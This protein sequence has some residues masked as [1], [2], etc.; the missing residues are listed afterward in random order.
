MDI[1]ERS[2]QECREPQETHCD[3]DRALLRD[4]EEHQSGRMISQRWHETLAYVWAKR[5]AAAYWVGGVRVEDV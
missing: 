4:G 2:S 3:A 1:Q 5:L